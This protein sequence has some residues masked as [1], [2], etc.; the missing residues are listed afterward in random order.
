[1]E[2]TSSGRLEGGETNENEKENARETRS[3]SMAEI[4]TI[5]G[6]QFQV[7][8]DPSDID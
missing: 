4:E 8:R 7:R 2:I 5:R 6:D 1:M 3:C